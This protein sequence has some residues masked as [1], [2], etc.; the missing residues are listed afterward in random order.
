M[1]NRLASI[2]ASE[3]HSFAFWLLN[4]CKYFHI[5]LPDNISILKLLTSRVQGET[6][7]NQQNEETI[8]GANTTLRICYITGYYWY[9]V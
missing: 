6:C 5:R 2:T 7:I 9:Q 8:Y 4:L 1:K 3:S